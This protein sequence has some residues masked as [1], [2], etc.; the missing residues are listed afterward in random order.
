M[1]KTPHRPG[2]Q[3][4]ADHPQAVTISK[5]CL[6]ILRWVTSD[7]VRR[8]PHIGVA[9][10]DWFGDVVDFHITP[11]TCVVTDVTP[12]QHRSSVARRTCRERL[13]V[14]RRDPADRQGGEHVTGLRVYGVEQGSPA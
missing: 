4:L 2:D 11:L 8:S 5:K 12:P 3:A 13:G 6:G 7:A 9:E 14:P 1:R 10:F